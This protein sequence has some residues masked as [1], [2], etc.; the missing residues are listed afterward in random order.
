MAS[1]TQLWDLFPGETFRFTP[2]GPLLQYLGYSSETRTHQIIP[3]DVVIEEHSGST[4][5]LP[6]E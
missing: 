6:G 2:E 4:P 5:I 3:A 1:P